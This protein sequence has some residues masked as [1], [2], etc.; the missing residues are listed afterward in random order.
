L[1]FGHWPHCSTQH[2]Q[3]RLLLSDA[4]G[5]VRQLTSASNSVT[6]AR[7]YQPYG[8]VLSS[9]G[10]GATSYA[11]V[12]EWQDGTSLIHLRARYYSGGQGRFITADPWRGN[13]GRPLTLNKWNYVNGNPIN[14][15][16]PS[17]QCVLGFV[18]DTLA[19]ILV[20]GGIV[21]V[22]AIL[23]IAPSIYLIENAPEVAREIEDV[24]A[25]CERI[26]EQAFRKPQIRI[27]DPFAPLPQPRSSRNSPQ[28]IVELGAGDY[29]NAIAMKLA[30]PGARVI[31]TNLVEEWALGRDLYNAGYTS[32][33]Y[34]A[35][36]HAVRV[37]LGW[38][39]AKAA[40]IEAG[41]T[42]PLE[43]HQV[44]TGI[45]DLVYAILPY[46]STAYSFG[47]DAA[48]IASTKPGTR[49]AV[50]EGG[51]GSSDHFV[52][53]FNSTRPGST[54]SIIP[55]ALYGQPHSDWEAG[56]Y[57]TQEYVVP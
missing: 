6:L 48:R 35:K 47:S 37:Y 36:S 24:L 28:V 53:G 16:D 57:F 19:C 17:G 42:Q 33:D 44:S 32:P 23:A 31:A 46:P 38:L 34:I 52:R 27:G 13:Y 40:G 10:A 55:G 45:G 14:Y 54:F 25:E 41:A 18:A 4:L 49:V 43:N 8:T 50:T 5:S 15:R 22:V 56:P 9:T 20:V 29:S 7:T 11:F 21:I 26:V 3:Y 2:H 12:G 51:S 30:N 39:S 1:H